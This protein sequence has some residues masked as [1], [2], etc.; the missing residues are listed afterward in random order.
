MPGDDLATVARFAA[1]V[2]EQ[3]NL[4]VMD[5]LVNSDSDTV[6][7][8]ELKDL[9]AT[10]KDEAPGLGFSIDTLEEREDVITGTLHLTAPIGIRMAFGRISSIELPEYLFPDDAPTPPAVETT[11]DETDTPDELAARL[12]E[13]QRTIDA[14]AA[15]LAGNVER[16]ERVKRDADEARKS[17]KLWA[18]LAA[19]ARARGDDRSVKRTEAHIQAQ[20]KRVEAY[21]QQLDAL[22]SVID[23]L[24]AYVRSSEERLLRFELR[25]EEL[26]A[27]RRLASVVDGLEIANAGVTDIAERIIRM[28]DQMREAESESTKTLERSLRSYKSRL[29][30]LRVLHARW[31]PDLEARLQAIAAE[32]EPRRA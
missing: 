17:Q 29:E 10:I 13:L 23:R 20:R 22:G 12:E 16:F 4:E 8:A 15:Q 26:E 3:G 1:E 27:R 5:E 19:S 11:G 2:L 25:A 31:T 18:G 30:S 6:D 32:I 7:W 14:V 24:S 28:E 21:D 9:L